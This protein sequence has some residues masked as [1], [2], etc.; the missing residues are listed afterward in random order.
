MLVS[1]EHA[2]LK[3][4]MI[5]QIKHGCTKERKQ[6]CAACTQDVNVHKHK[7]TWAQALALSVLVDMYEETPGY[8]HTSDI[9]SLTRDRAKKPNLILT[10]FSV[11]AKWSLIEDE[12]N[13]TDPEKRT[14]GM[15]RPTIRG[16]D[17]VYDRYRI[18]HY[19]W[20]FDNKIMHESS[21]LVS[22]KDTTGEQYS[23]P[24]MKGIKAGTYEKRQPTQVP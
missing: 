17:F 15:W 11:M 14:S 18:S 2:R 4:G 5:G 20:T 19:L 10:H 7:V 16:I 23:W 22:I 9:N 3:E 8:H 6:K 21:D 1:E 12:P 24:E 13:F